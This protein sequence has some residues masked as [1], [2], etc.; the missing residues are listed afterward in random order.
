M[1]AHV[2]TITFDCREPYPLAR[3]WSAVLGYTDHPDNPNLPDD[4]EALIVDPR[5]LSPALLFIPVPEPKTVKNRVHVDLQPEVGRD[6]MVERV[7]ALGGSIVGDHRRDDGSGWV[8]MADPEGNELCVERSAAER[9]EQRLPVEVHRPRFDAR[10]ADERSMLEAML[11]WYRAGIVAKVE[12]VSQWHAAARPL[13]SET[14]ICGL[15]KH[16]TL[17]EGWFPYDFAGGPVDPAFA[18]IDWRVDSNWEFRTARDEPIEDL[19]AAYATA[20][21]RSRAAVAGRDLDELGANPDGDPP[22]TLRYV[23]VHMIEETA[24]HLG[25]LDIL[26]E[27]LDGTTGD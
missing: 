4:P 10:T 11:D 2:R 19:V 13:A 26:R 14:S 25:H 8:V 7:L 23:Y 21:E 12:G 22:F 15:V 18:G 3:F 27:L 16:L 24:R 6:E 17:V 20:C 1:T 9:P 5:G